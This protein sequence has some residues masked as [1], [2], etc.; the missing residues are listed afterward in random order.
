M[1]PLK[2]GQ[3][4]PSHKVVVHG[5]AEECTCFSDP[6]QPPG[7]FQPRWDAHLMTI[8]PLAKPCST[9][10][11]LQVVLIDREKQFLGLFCGQHLVGL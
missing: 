6:W 11:T 2:E 8:E 7:T 9:G 3:Y 10:W 1:A 4:V 5:L